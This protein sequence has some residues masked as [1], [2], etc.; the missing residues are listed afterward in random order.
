MQVPE[1]LAEQHPSSCQADKHG[2]FFNSFRSL[3]HAQALHCIALEVDDIAHLPHSTEVARRAFAIAISGRDRI[4]RNPAGRNV[5]QIPIREAS[6]I[7][8]DFMIPKSP[9]WG[10]AM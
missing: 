6:L 2:L 5:P 9:D 4:D 3:R 8:G 7:L 10:T 1:L